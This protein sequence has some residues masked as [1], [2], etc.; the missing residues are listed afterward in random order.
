MR[1][2]GPAVVAGRVGPS[3]A[4]ALALAFAFALPARA[5]AQLPLQ[6]PSPPSP[7]APKPPEE[8][9]ITDIGV[10][11]AAPPPPQPPSP[12]T[13]PLEPPN[14]QPEPARLTKDEVPDPGYLPGYGKVP[15]LGLSPYT[16][17][18]CAFPCGR[19]ATH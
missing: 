10:P 17:S 8:K 18:V 11:Q 1:R 19:A 12:A 13:K 4:S 15:S 2:P 3:V 7:E 16:P 9:P 6:P 14:A 5:S